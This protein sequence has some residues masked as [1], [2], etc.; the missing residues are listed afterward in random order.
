M[1]KQTEKEL[2]KHI[3]AKG[4]CWRAERFSEAG[5]RADLRGPWQILLLDAHFQRCAKPRRGGICDA[6]AIY[7]SKASTRLRLL[8]LKQSLDDLPGAFKQLRKGGEKVAEA[9]PGGF[10]GLNVVAELHVR[11][12]PTNTRKLRQWMLI[13]GRKVPVRAYREGSPV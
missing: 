8:E 6:V 9:L 2:R 4:G 13:G 7:P 5:V 3:C 11:K 12:A 1:S 10:A